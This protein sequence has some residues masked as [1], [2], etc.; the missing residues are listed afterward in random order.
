MEALQIVSTFQ[1]V[2]TPDDQYLLKDI[3]E[4]TKPSVPAECMGLHYLYM[5]PFQYG[6]FPSGPCFRKAGQVFMP[7]ESFGMSQCLFHP[8]SGKPTL[9]GKIFSVPQKVFDTFSPDCIRY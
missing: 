3:L 1:L 5:T 9:C 7:S 4:E 8:K 2:G 6:N